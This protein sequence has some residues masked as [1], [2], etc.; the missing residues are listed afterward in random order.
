MTDDQSAQTRDRLSKALFDRWSR[1]YDSGRITSWFQYTQDLA[2]SNLALRPDSR[3]LDVGCGTGWA[4]LR[5]AELCPEGRACGIDI[6]D[7]MIEQARSKVAEPDRGRIEFRRASSDALP[8]EAGTFTHMICTNSFHHY[9][10]P[11]GTLGEMGRVLEPGG[12]LVIFENARELSWYVWAWDRFLRW[13]EPG[14]VR[15][16]TSSELGGFLEEAG[17]VARELRVLR[18]EFRKHGKLFAS[19]QVWSARTPGGGAAAE[20]PRA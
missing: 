9:P 6:S 11:V 3:V 5:A 14:H 1:S 16:Y 20:E 8:F 12:Q 19:M 18:N 10:D 2:I 15:Y 4:T 17:Y 7:G 13:F